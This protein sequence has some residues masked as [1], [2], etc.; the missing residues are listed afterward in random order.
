MG[1][2]LTSISNFTAFTGLESINFSDNSLSTFS[3][4]GSFPNLTI[5]SITRNELTS[6]DI[7]NLTDLISFYINSNPLTDINIVSNI[8]LKFVGIGNAEL[9]E[10]AVNNILIQLD[11]NGLTN[12]GV[13][14]SYGGNAAPTGAGIT[15]KNN[16]IS[17]SWTVQTN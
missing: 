9:S 5:I 1:A 8:N 17:K 10:S 6:I 7:S 2:R 16:L 13:G 12:G 4:S 3:M 15:A 11:N 14:L